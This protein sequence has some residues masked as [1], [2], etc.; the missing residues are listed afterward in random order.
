MIYLDNVV[1][2]VLI[3][4]VIEKMINVMISNYGN[5]FSIYI[6]GC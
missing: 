4:F 5:L 1:I 3:L 2:I 6:F